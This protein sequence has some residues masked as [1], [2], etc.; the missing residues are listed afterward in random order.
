MDRLAI[1]GIES[2]EEL[3]LTAGRLKATNKLSFTDA[4]ISATAV[5]YDSTLVYKDPDFAQLENEGKVLKLP[6][7]YKLIQIYMPE[8]S[9]TQHSH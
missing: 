6:L 2:S 3:G 4:G 5:L 1:T 9:T 7:P 8:Q